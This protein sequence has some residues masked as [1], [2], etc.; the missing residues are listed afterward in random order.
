MDGDPVTWSEARREQ[1]GRKPTSIDGQE[2]RRR[3]GPV[4]EA[5]NRSRR[6]EEIE[7]GVAHEH[8]CRTPDRRP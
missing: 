6:L 3:D 8:Q 4:V 5:D 1:H 7:H 2:L